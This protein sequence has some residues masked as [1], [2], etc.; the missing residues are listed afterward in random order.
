MVH[1]EHDIALTVKLK[2]LSNALAANAAPLQ[3]R[4]QF[5]MVRTTLGRRTQT[6][7]SPTVATLSGA[8]GCR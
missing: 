6:V 8:G 2:P 7:Y 4:S 1:L 5:Q 3:D